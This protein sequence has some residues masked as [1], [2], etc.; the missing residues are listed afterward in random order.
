MISQKSGHVFERAVI[1]KII[2]S[3][4]RC[5]VTNEPLTLGDIVAVQAPEKVVQ[6]RAPSDTSITNLLK[7]FQNEWDALML[8]SFKLKKN[9][10]S[11]R[12][13]LSH[14]LY[15]PDAAC[16]VIAR[17]VKERDQARAELANT[18]QSMSIAI[19][20]SQRGMMEVDE[21]GMDDITIQRIKT[22]AEELSALRKKNKKA[23]EKLSK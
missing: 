15:Q 2:K 22:K 8:E 1:E 10:H 9:L 19:Q 18:Q 12:Q 5:P 7:I 14:A 6:A 13:E 20:G 11:V 23:S 3:E 21:A 16:R 17:V 4:G